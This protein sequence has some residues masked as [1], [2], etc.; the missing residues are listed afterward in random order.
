MA[1][2]GS[3]IWHRSKFFLLERNQYGMYMPDVMIVN[4]TAYMAFI[5]GNSSNSLLMLKHSSFLKTVLPGLFILVIYTFPL[6]ISKCT[7]LNAINQNPLKC[8]IGIFL[9]IWILFFDLN[10]KT[11][12]FYLILI[13]CSPAEIRQSIGHYSSYFYLCNMQSVIA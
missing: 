6:S 9:G 13:S 11:I 10:K 4:N 8:Q 7:I 2:Y 5:F 12:S 3:L 1:T